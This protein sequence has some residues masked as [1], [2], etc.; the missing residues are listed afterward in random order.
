MAGEGKMS[1]GDYTAAM[2]RIHHLFKARDEMHA[3]SVKLH[4]MGKE[5]SQGHRGVAWLRVQVT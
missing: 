4:L 5:R 1:D 2:P 3:I